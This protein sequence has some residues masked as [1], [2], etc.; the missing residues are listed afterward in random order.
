MPTFIRNHS[1]AHSGEEKAFHYYLSFVNIIALDRNSRCCAGIVLWMY[2][3]VDQCGWMLHVCT[4]WCWCVVGPRKYNSHESHLRPNMWFLCNNHIVYA[5]VSFHSETVCVYF[6]ELNWIIYTAVA[7][8]FFF[9]A[10]RP[11]LAPFLPHRGFIPPVVVVAVFFF[12]SSDVFKMKNKRLEIIDSFR[13]LNCIL[14][15]AHQ[16]SIVARPYRAGINN[17]RQRTERQRQAN[18]ARSWSVPKSTPKINEIQHAKLVSL[19]SQRSRLRMEWEISRSSGAAYH[20]RVEHF[21][22]F[23]RAGEGADDGELTHRWQVKMKGLM[24]I[25]VGYRFY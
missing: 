13:I 1:Y 7:F 15:G 6:A 23:H 19:A 5:P 16:R 10:V 25:C 24:G 8:L 18:Q 22:N 21:S 14:R 12:A 20:Q 3:W 11:V 2:G 17:G 4:Y 9:F